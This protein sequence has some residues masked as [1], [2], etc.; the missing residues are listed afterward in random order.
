MKKKISLLLSILML[1][2]VGACSK[3][4]ASTSND[5]T[6]NAL[7]A[8]NPVILLNGFDTVDDLYTARMDSSA[9]GKAELSTEKVKA[10]EKSLKVE[11]LSDT[12]D[13]RNAP[14]FFQSNKLTKAN[15]DYTDWS[16]VKAGTMD[17][18]NAQNTECKIGVQP[19]YSSTSGLTDWFTLAPESWTTVKYM[20]ERE[21]IVATTDSKGKEQR[22][23][24]GF[25]VIFERQKADETFYVD[26][27]CLYKTEA[28]YTPVSM[29]LGEDEICSFDFYWQIKKLSPTGTASPVI[30]YTKEFSSD[31]VGA[32]LCI[33]KPLVETSAGWSYVDIPLSYINM[34]TNEEWGAYDDNDLMC[35][36]VYSQSQDLL[37]SARLA[38]HAENGLVMYIGP[39]FDTLKVGEWN[40]I[41]Y[42]VSDMLSYVYTGYAQNPAT[43]F[44]ELGKLRFM[45]GR[46][47]K[48]EGLLYVD[49]LRM[50]RVANDE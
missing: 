43:S 30:T 44:A 31:G 23:V 34:R 17:V 8:T 20:V 7:T 28:K 4:N 36:E 21:Y 9:L 24:S 50:V 42:K 22:I 32:S 46:D 14:Y 12:L 6:D 26:N 41:S 2:C 15:A 39:T 16:N 47:D 29:S 10:G 35:F 1:F 13:N 33:D 3:Y 5:S 27:M 38:V 49:N 19:V 18:Y 48:T 25:N 40:T 11:V 45:F 37:N